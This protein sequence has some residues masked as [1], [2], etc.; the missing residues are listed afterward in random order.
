MNHST[1]ATRAHHMFNSLLKRGRAGL[2]A[3]AALLALSQ[4][5]VQ[6][7]QAAIGTVDVVP[8]ATLLLPYFEVDLAN[9]NGKQTAFRISNTSATAILVNVVLWTDLGVPTYSFQ[10]YQVGYNTQDVDLRLVFKGIM[11]VTASAGQ[12]PAD[13]ISPKGQFSQDIN[14]SSCGPPSMGVPGILPQVGLLPAATVTALRNAHTG[15]GSTL[16]SGNCGGSVKGD[17]IARGYITMD[18][19]NQCTT[20]RPGDVGYFAPFNQGIATNQNVMTGTVTY[21]NRSQ[22]LAY[23]DPLVHIEASSTHPLT[24]SAAGQNTFYGRYVGFNGDDNREPLAV[25]S[26]ARYM[27]GGAFT[28]GSDFMVWRDSGAAVVPFACGSNA[29]GYPLPQKEV[30]AFDEQENGTPFVGN[31]FPIASQI[32]ASSTLTPY[33]FGTLRMH[34]GI[35]SGNAAVMGR[36]QSYVSVRHTASGLY[37]GS[38]PAAQ[39]FNASG[40]AASASTVDN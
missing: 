39:I 8:A 22:N 20:A 36:Q 16:L 27:N 28:G 4:V 31:A 24:Q 38:L 35:N 5:S 9:E 25:V 13:R 26:Q 32:V 15:A 30:I 7:A 1:I 6:S 12:D 33:A 37:G 18:V 17:N 23:S 34:L 2:C 19:V 21:L 14:F 10:I 40:S 29:A 11:P 3:V